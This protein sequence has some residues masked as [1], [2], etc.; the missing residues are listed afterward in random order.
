[1]SKN[2]DSPNLYHGN[3]EVMNAISMLYLFKLYPEDIQIVFMESIGL[4]DDPFY[5]IYKYMISFGTEPIYIYIKF[6]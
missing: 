3:W 4:P 6:N 1:M 5:D 2:Q